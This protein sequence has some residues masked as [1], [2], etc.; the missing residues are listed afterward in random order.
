MQ[1]DRAISLR[2]PLDLAHR[3]EAH[4]AKVNAARGEQKTGPLSTSEVTRKLL[5]I[6]LVVRERDAD[7]MED[8]FADLFA[9]K[10]AAAL[11]LGVTDTGVRKLLKKIAADSPTTPEP[12][13]G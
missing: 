10:L 6:G 5:V 13:F 1:A 8:Y 3:I 9:D 11:A 2:L 4:A 12:D 7:A